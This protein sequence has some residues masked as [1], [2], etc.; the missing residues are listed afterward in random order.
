MRSNASKGLISNDFVNFRML[1]LGIRCIT[2]SLL[3]Y[4]ILREV[5][6]DEAVQLF[7]GARLSS[8]TDPLVELAVGE[9][10]R[11]KRIFC[12]EQFAR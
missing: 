3:P 9:I 11:S 1:P 6:T 8:L 12:K 10:P 4:E 5:A 2:V 7:A